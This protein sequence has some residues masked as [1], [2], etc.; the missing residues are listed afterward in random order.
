MTD[1]Y[2]QTNQAPEAPIPTSPQ[3]AQKVPFDW[4]SLPGRIKPFLIS[5]FTKFYS[6]K[7]IF[8][9]VSIIFGTLFLVIIL[10]LLFGNRDKAPVVLNTPTPTPIILSTPEASTSGDVII[11]SQKKLN[12]LKNQ[13]NTLDPEQSRL[14]PPDLN[15]NIKF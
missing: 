3:V 6:N 2:Q 11:D 9:L 13:I 4:K 12:D 7:K 8:W 5:L 14:K 1:I 10:G 15:F